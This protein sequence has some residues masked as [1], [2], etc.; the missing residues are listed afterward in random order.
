MNEKDSRKERMPRSYITY[1]SHFCH[2]CYVLRELLGA[3]VAM[4]LGGGVGFAWCEE[5]PISQGI[6]FA[7]ITST[8][9]GFG[10]ITPQT[11]LGQWVAVALAL[12]GTVFFGLV[13]AVATQAFRVTISEYMHV[14]GKKF[15]HA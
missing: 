11:G 2:Y 3:H 1:L 15:P 5:I 6:Y 14:R 4:V 8:T 12:V 10:D 9:V 7:L 13:V